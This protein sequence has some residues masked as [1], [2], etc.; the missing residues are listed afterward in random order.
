MALDTADTG[1]AAPLVEARSVTLRLGDRPAL[2]NVDL[3][4]RA[5]EIV[6]VVGPNGAGKT[7]LIRV[8]LGL[9]APDSGEV[10]RRHGVRIGYVPQHFVVDETLPL[11]VRRFLRLGATGNGKQDGKRDRDKAS[12]VLE[13]VGAL[14]VLDRPVQVLSGGEMKR[15]LLARALLRDP[16]LL[17]LDEPSAGVDVAGQADLY[18]LVRAIRDRR[19]CG[20]VLVSHNLHLVMAA[21]DHVICLN[22]HVCC[23]GRPE[24]VSRE[25]EF[26]AMFGA[27]VAT[28]IAAEIGVYTHQHDHRHDVSGTAVPGSSPGGGSGRGGSGRGDSNG[29]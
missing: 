28:G 3:A 8:L 23:E 20:V 25:P 21:T 13:E 26:L 16:D 19:D 9:I 12:A 4:V 1:D 2:E 24:A 29:G 10:R 14:H 15:M 11:T 6:T 22:R 18:A 27:G 5:G 17:V 7:T